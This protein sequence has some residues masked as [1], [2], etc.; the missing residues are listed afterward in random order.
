MKFKTYLKALNGLFY[1]IDED[2]ERH[3]I[4]E[5]TLTI[6]KSNDGKQFIKTD[7]GLVEFEIEK[8]VK[9]DVKEP[10][11]VQRALKQIQD[12][13]VGVSRTHS[14]IHTLAKAVEKLAAAGAGEEKT[15]NRR[16]E[17]E[18]DSA[19]LTNAKADEIFKS[20]VP[21]V[22]IWREKTARVGYSL[23]RKVSLGKR[24]RTRFY[25]AIQNFWHS[26][27]NARALG[28]FNFHFVDFW[29]VKLDDFLAGRFF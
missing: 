27:G 20:I 18:T 14:E 16:G 13:V 10:D 8:R 24:S 11:S 26:P 29:T 9:I 21:G 28:T 15:W 7:D 12:T 4:D 6:L 23:K 2:G 25:P 17:F 22:K 1:G 5:K 3:A 19:T